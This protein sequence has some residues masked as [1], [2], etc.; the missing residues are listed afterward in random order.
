MLSKLLT[1][2]IAVLA[3]IAPLGHTGELA[4][5]PGGSGS[6][7]VI[8]DYYGSEID[9]S[10]GWGTAQACAITPTE[11]ICFDTERELD[12]HLNVGLQADCGTSV[13]L[14]AGTSYGLPVLSI[15]QRLTWRN[16]ASSGFDNRTRSYKIGA[17]AAA[18]AKD[19]NGGGGYYPGSTRAGAQ[20]STM[21]S[22]WDSQV[23]S[24]YLY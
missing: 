6:S 4:A 12:S 23:S 9:L 18:F 19:S 10:Q 1:P 15:T 24:V 13:R 14:Y 20:S 5:A 16:L 3:A 17:C 22:G 8:A 21:L 7:G 11:A 2:A